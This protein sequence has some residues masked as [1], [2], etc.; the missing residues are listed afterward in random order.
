MRWNRSLRECPGHGRF[1]S[2]RG[3]PGDGRRQRLQHP[4][5]AAHG[6]DSLLR[7]CRR[8]LRRN[9]G[10]PVKLVRIVLVCLIVVLLTA[11]FLTLAVIATAPWLV[12]AALIGPPR[13]SIRPAPETPVPGIA[14][15]ASAN[16]DLVAR[17][18]AAAL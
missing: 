9:R 7:R 14:P 3:D 16:G 11:P 17:I 4:G 10:A 18:V 2:W 6:P 13:V 15:S 1:R 12:G 5:R 8:H